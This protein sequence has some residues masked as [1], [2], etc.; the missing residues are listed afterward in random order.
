MSRIN[1]RILR[2]FVGVGHICGIKHIRTQRI[3]KQK[4]D[5]VTRD[6][7]VVAQ[8]L[9]GVVKKAILTEFKIIFAKFAFAHN[10]KL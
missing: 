7:I 4:Q 1:G 8:W 3:T 9:F 10:T 5:I 6:F 2:E